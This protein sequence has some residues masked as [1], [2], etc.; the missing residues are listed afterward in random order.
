MSCTKRLEMGGMTL[1]IHEYPLDAYPS[2]PE[3][4]AKKEKSKIIEKPYLSIEEKALS[5]NSKKG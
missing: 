1:D 5:I 4:Q 2:C 3:W